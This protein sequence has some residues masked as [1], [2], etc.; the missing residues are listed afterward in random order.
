MRVVHVN[1]PE[2]SIAAKNL[3][4]SLG[5]NCVRRFL[6][7][8]L[9]LSDIHL[10]DIENTSLLCRPLQCGEEDRLAQIQNRAFA[11][12]WGFNPNTTEEIAYRVNLS[13]CSHDHVV[14]ACDEGKPIAYCWTL[15]D[16]EEN[17]TTGK[18]VGRLHMLGVD[19]DCRRKGI[20]KTTLLA[21][22][23]FLRNKGMETAIL[24]VDSENKPAR[25]LHESLGFRIWL[26]TE[27]YE[28]SLI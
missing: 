13:N 4:H 1:V 3:L 26:T 28:K 14:V 12:T 25:T 23:S 6:E 18:R 11:E 22:V 9:E 17:A 8:S 21:G 16:Q 2:T 19:P 15:I 10:L 24:T 20:G 5:F 27:W 7:M